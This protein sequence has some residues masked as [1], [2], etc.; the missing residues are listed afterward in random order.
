MPMRR[1][2]VKSFL[3]GDA[4]H[5]AKAG[6]EEFVRSRFDP[7]GD[8]A[9]GRSSVGRVVLEAAVMG[10]IVRGGD[11]DAV[12]QSAFAP[13]VVCENRMG[14]HGRGSVFIALR[15]HH[16]DF[17]GRHHLQRAGQRGHG[18]RVRVDSQEQGAVDA[19]LLAVE[20]DGLADS[21]DM[22]LVESPVERGAAMAGSAEGHA[23]RRHRRIG[24]FG[25][26]SR[27]EI[28]NVDQRGR[29][30]RR[31][32]EGTHFH[33]CALCVPRSVAAPR[34]MI[35]RLRFVSTSAAMS[36]LGRAAS[37]RRRIGDKLRWPG[38]RAREDPF[39]PGRKTD[40]RKAAQQTDNRRRAA[41][42]Q[43]RDASRGRLSA[44]ATSTSRSSASP[45]ATARS[46]RATSG[47]DVLAKRAEAAV[48]RRGRDAA[49][50]RHD[51]RQRRH[52]DGHRGHEVL[53][54]L[55]RGHRRFDRDRLQRRRAWT[56]CSRSA[57]ATRTCPAR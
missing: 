38:A 36:A 20:A 34:S 41:L 18:E 14:E 49:D 56:A 30:G 33:F 10:R 52:L 44:T 31:S 3:V 21:E 25:I 23:L 50:L 48:A 15:D 53:A 26:V 9:R 29:V 28:R 37:H 45:T 42:A 4:L 22:A 6:L 46:R 47:L 1:R 57:A 54:G 32:C 5:T 2:G 51:H 43:P 39:S 55:A 12:G 27:D 16:L 7:A 11:D 40:G 24:A 17:V 8:G 35:Q 19:L 13:A